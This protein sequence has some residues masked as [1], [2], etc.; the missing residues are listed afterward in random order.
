MQKISLKKLDV[1]S[2]LQRKKE[3]YVLTILVFT[4]SCKDF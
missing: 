3:D 2:I 4:S 1:V